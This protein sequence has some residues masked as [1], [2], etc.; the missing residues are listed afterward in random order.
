MPNFPNGRREHLNQK[1]S[2][3]RHRSD[4]T[5]VSTT[6]A[7]QRI[8]P[9][10]QLLSQLVHRYIPKRLSQRA[11]WLF[12][13]FDPRPRSFLHSFWRSR[14]SCC[15]GGGSRETK[16]WRGAAETSMKRTLATVTP[17]R[18]GSA[19]SQQLGRSSKTQSIAGVAEQEQRQRIAAELPAL[20]RQCCRCIAWKL[21]KVSCANRKQQQVHTLNWQ[22]SAAFWAMSSL[23]RR[24]A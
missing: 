16:D 20:L 11:C 24:N 3:Q 17:F 7:P 5:G 23:H 15:T 1:R 18:S 13:T 14:G 21:G 8:I 2:A 4:T 12:R 22:V 19:R 9:W 6:C 10:A